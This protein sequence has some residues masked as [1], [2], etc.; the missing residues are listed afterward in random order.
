MLYKTKPNKSL[1]DDRVSYEF[2]K[3]ALEELI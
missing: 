3:H 2:F 1:E